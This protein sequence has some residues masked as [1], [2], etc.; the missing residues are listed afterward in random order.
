MQHIELLIVAKIIVNRE[1]LR[2]IRIFL[3]G[4]AVRTLVSNPKIFEFDS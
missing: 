2:D 3:I 4:E 1:I